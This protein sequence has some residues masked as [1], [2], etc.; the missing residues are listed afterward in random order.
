MQGT[1]ADLDLASLAAVT[2]LGR[3][4]LRLEVT[5][6]AGALVGQLV[7]KAGRVVSATAG[8]AHGRHAMHVI[9]RSTASTRFRLMREPLDYVLSSALASVE[10]LA[11]LGSPRL[12]RSSTGL[13]VAEAR[14]PARRSSQGATRVGMMQGR[15]DEFD[16]PTLFQVIG[17]GRS[18]VE[19]VVLNETGAKVGIV[20]LKAGHVVSARTRD[21]NGLAAV[22][23]LMHAPKSFAFAAFRIDAELGQI[24]ALGSVSEIILRSQAH[25]P[26][27]PSRSEPP[28]ITGT[29]PIMEGSLDEFDVA[30][31]LQTA[32]CGRQH[33]AL[34]I[35]DDQRVV[36]TIHVKS[37]IVVSA[38]AGPLTAIAAIEHLIGL[39]APHRFRMNRVTAAVGA[40]APVGS[41]SQ[42]L[43]Q[44]DPLPVSVPV[45]PPPPSPDFEQDAVTASP[46][47]SAPAPAAY[48]DDPVGRPI[49]AELLPVMEGNLADFDF[50]TLLEALAVTRQYSHLQILDRNHGLIGELRLKSGMMVSV[51]AE[52]RHGVDAL[53]V[54]LGVAPHFRFRVLTG[55]FDVGATPLGSVH[56]LLAVFAPRVVPPSERASRVI[57]AVIPISF[58]LG[59][60]IVF[61][62]IRGGGTTATS[63]EGAIVQMKS[64]PPAAITAKEAPQADSPSPPASPPP[65]SPPPASPPPV[66][67][68][69]APGVSNHGETIH[70]AGA[71]GPA[72][73]HL[74]PHLPPDRPVHAGTSIKV[75][76]AAL[77]R[78]GYDPG[79]SDNVYGTLTRSAILKFQAD[80][81]LPRTGVLDGET[82]SAIVALLTGN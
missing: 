64:S 54:L 58:F 59:G 2:S 66:A 72:D 63:G 73:E 55:R 21:R 45:P 61:F 4:S 15:L 82:W 65:A 53:K 29:V 48:R 9:M 77:K 13:P 40:H 75:A 41:V 14:R 79:P 18:Y 47:A 42:V 56:E 51:H 7:L 37:G 80:H 26:P 1:L 62:V 25:A 30:T 20:G 46:P 70:Q 43:L 28:S 27:P 8:E 33:C 52:G 49:A 68:A 50:R 39:R 34:E 78:L 60:A 6:P 5:D 74:E 22:S 17:M 57:R 3:S 32:A 71:A 69:L 44:I 19:L 24:E 36:G 76:Q 35:C 81:A 12:A 10:E 67:Q 23:E 16:L 31:L 11:E 38:G